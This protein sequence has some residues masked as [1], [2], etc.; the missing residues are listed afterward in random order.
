MAVDLDKYLG[1]EQSFIKHSFLTQY[2]QAAAYKVLQGRSPVFNFVDAFAGPWNVSDQNYSD[3][4]FDQALR[5]LDTVRGDLD[6]RGIG[7]L[8][9]R[10]CF[11]E[12]RGEAVNE[13]RAYAKQKGRFEIHVF[14]GSFEDHLDG[15]SSAC[16]D[17]FTF[18]FIDPTGWNMRSEPVF[19]FLRDQRGEFLL[20][21]MAE[22]VNRHAEF[23]NVAASFGRFLADPD[24]EDD[25]NRL[26][27]EWSNEQRVLYLLKK[28]VKA[29]GAATYLPDFPIMKP[30]ENRVK[31]RLI[32]GTHSAR[33][34]EVF[35]DVQEKVERIE[36][37]T[38]NQ[39]RTPSSQQVGLFSDSEIAA[40]EQNITGVGCPMYQREAEQQI[41]ACLT[42]RQ[43]V[44]FSEITSSVLEAVPI[45]LTQLKELVGQLRARDLIAYD[46]PLRKRVPQPETRIRLG[47][48][49]I[50]ERNF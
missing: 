47:D 33:G 23:P 17:G 35:R 8:K 28:K 27:S 37:E 49:K 16:H 11:C 46:L 32:L 10:F 7:G 29:T 20:N 18:T 1:R 26:Q 43:F 39:L 36:I 42:G 30:R 5:T 15:I 45:R 14:H 21:F 34:L 48:P 25:F 4:S 22:H 19:R 41:V 38:R 44:P 6:R 9:I 50:G 40:L 12:K 2:L 13:L 24:W 3:A 31:M